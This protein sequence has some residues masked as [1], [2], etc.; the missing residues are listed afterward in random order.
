[1]R[2]SSSCTARSTY[3]FTS[4]IRFT[5]LVICR[6]SFRPSAVSSIFP[7]MRGYKLLSLLAVLVV[8]GCGGGA[9]EQAPQTVAGPGYR[10]AVPAGWDVTRSART[11]SAESDGR[12]VSV[13]VFR[14]TR[15]YRPALFQ[16]VVRELDR[17]A[18]DLARKL[19]GAPGRG[20]TVV[21]DGRKARAYATSFTRE[22]DDFD[23]R[24]V[25]V[26]R[27]RSEYQILCRWPSG[28]DSEFCDRAVASFRLT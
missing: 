2:S 24:V 14:L 17:V 3:G 11:V 28:Q 5:A 20:R 8:A 12:L 9:D 10:L 15:P 1:M 23:Q 13:T 27:G 26:L 21:V 7:R 19:G 18:A 4:E 16:A 25:F 6:L 22:G